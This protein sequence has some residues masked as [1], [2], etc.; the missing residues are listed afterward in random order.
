MPNFLLNLLKMKR[1]KT[2][3]TSVSAINALDIDKPNQKD[4]KIRNTITREE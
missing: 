3:A 2:I 1:R 4:K